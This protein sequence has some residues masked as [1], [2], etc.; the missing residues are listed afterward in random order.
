MINRNIKLGI[1]FSLFTLTICTVSYAEDL[2]S[3]S[4]RDQEMM[5]QRRIAREALKERVAQI[6]Q[7]NQAKMHEEQAKIQAQ[8]HNIMQH[9]HDSTAPQS[10]NSTEF[11][12]PTEPLNRPTTSTTQDQTDKTNSIL[13]KLLILLPLIAL[14]IFWFRN[15]RKNKPT[16]YD[17]KIQTNSSPQNTNNKPT[18]NLKPPQSQPS[19]QVGLSKLS[20]KKDSE[21]ELPNGIY[22]Y[23]END[24]VPFDENYETF[25][26]E[27]YEL[28]VIPGITENAES[29]FKAFL[30]DFYIKIDEFKNTGKSNII[31][32]YNMVRTIPFELEGGRYFLELPHTNRI[33]IIE[34]AIEI[35]KKHQLIIM[36]EE[37]ETFFFPSGRVEPDM[38]WR[39]NMTDTKIEDNSFPRTVA[40]FEKNLEPDLTNLLVNHGFV[41]CTLPFFDS[42]N[43]YVKEV[44][45]GKIYAGTSVDKRKWGG[46][47]FDLYFYFIN[48][49]AVSIYNQTYSA[50][51]FYSCS[52]NLSDI[53]KELTIENF[54]E[55]KAAL[56]KINQVLLVDLIDHI[57]TL[58][59][60]D[61]LMNGFTNIK[62]RDNAKKA[63]ALIVAKL[64]NNPNFENLVLKWEFLE[65]NRYNDKPLERTQLIQYLRDNYTYH[66]ANENN[67]EKQPS[68]SQK[69][70][71]TELSHLSCDTLYIWDPKQ[72]K[73][74]PE[75][76]IIAQQCVLMLLQQKLRSSSTNSILSFIQKVEQRFVQHYI[77][78]P[79]FI[80]LYGNLANNFKLHVDILAQIPLPK[81]NRLVARHEIIRI[82]T[83]NGLVVYDGQSNAV[84]FPDELSFKQRMLMFADKYKEL[85]ET[86]KNNKYSYYD[87]ESNGGSQ[88]YELVVHKLPLLEE[89]SFAVELPEE[90]WGVMKSIWRDYAQECGLTL[91]EQGPIFLK[92]G[93]IF[94]KQQY[95]SYSQDGLWRASLKYLDFK[96]RNQLRP[97]PNTFSNIL[98]TIPL[99]DDLMAKY[100]FKKSVLPLLFDIVGYFH[101]TQDCTQYLA[102]NIYATSINVSVYISVNHIETIYQKFAFSPIVNVFSFFVP[103]R[104]NRDSDSINYQDVDDL[105][106]ETETK[107]LSLIVKLRTITE[108]DAAINGD[109]HPEIKASLKNETMPFRLILARLANNPNFE[110]LVNEFASVDAV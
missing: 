15:S 79:E 97:F 85:Y 8:F 109:N 108:L 29:I 64:V 39:H 25:Y 45:F 73:V 105:L 106:K 55:K 31:D 2:Q 21:I 68:L 87:E 86:S 70:Y 59:D 58:S 103:I 102:S 93:H 80:T 12:S 104:I 69:T 91:Y 20:L 22:L 11:R 35:A 84:F 74:E 94:P 32:F 67:L 63:N 27:I 95:K 100:D 53:G 16:T 34:F 54:S 76:E 13:V 42:E 57:E 10:F 60:L 51:E 19:D 98:P 72:Y 65:A 99:F 96:Q 52:I 30:N 88:L 4:S 17:E 9:Y 82:A 48:E 7:E 62:I 14:A 49:L 75:N 47:R 33:Q 36:V 46:F 81:I 24:L 71:S 37:I 83:E 66:E 1:F 89:D 43:G 110:S 5:E 18:Q 92:T 44:A 107:A 101:C 23:I 28:S 77:E 41:K 50:N 6:N 78:Y 61:Q 90:S 38:T 56:K 3:A 40:Q 26:E